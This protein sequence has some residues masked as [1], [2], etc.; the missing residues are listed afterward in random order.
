[1]QHHPHLAFAPMKVYRNANMQGL[2]FRRKAILNDAN[3]ND[4]KKLPKQGK[5]SYEAKNG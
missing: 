5:E 3:Q 1:M 4:Q 2:A